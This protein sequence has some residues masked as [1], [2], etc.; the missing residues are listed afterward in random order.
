MS[1]VHVA[2]IVDTPRQTL[3]IKSAV[4]VTPFCTN[5]LTTV[6]EGS[7]RSPR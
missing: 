3:A 5:L 6:A 1:F 7:A 4:S 2:L